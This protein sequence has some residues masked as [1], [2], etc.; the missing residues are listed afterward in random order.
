M[1]RRGIPY[2]L[3][4]LL[5]VIEH[6]AMDPY[7]RDLMTWAAKEIKHLQA[8]VTKKPAKG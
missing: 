1:R 6:H 8:Q 2:S 3:D 7:H 5:E 4:E